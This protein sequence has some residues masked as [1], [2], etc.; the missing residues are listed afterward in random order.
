MGGF[1]SGERVKKKTTVERCL[2]LDVGR[3]SNDVGIKPGV[4]SVGELTWTN[5]GEERILSVRFWL[6]PK[7]EDRA[8]LH[9]T[10]KV[11]AD[12]TETS[13]I[14][15]IVLT[16]TVPHFGGVRWWF[17]CLLIIDG[18]TCNRR[19]K[20]LFLPPGAKYFGCRTCYSLIYE[21]A[22]THDARIGKL[23]KNPLAIVKAIKSKDHRQALMG[24][25]AY[26]KLRGWM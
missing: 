16:G 7:S 8:V 17:I 11:E 12:R 1:G 21:S 23:M 10:S 14:E 15:P 26:A 9:I 20:K 4:Y 19:V 6:E 3:L 5:A 13:L 24:I 22:Q 18:T 2:K 25:Q